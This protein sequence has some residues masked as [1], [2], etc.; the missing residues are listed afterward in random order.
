MEG[1]QLPA[2]MVMALPN[3]HT[4]GTRPGLP[5]ARKSMEPQFDHIDA[6]EDDLFNRI[7]WFAMKGKDA[8]PRKFSGKEEEEVD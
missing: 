2:L 4:G 6:V 7:V 8:Y 1:D 5:T 3:D